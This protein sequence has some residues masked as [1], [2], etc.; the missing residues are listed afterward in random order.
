MFGKLITVLLSQAFALKTQWN[1]LKKTI[2]K[3]LWRKTAETQ[4]AHDVVLTL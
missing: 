3:T 1:S 4:E 2:I